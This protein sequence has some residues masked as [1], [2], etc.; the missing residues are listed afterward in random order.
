MTGR[1]RSVR[2]YSGVPIESDRF[3][4]AARWRGE[5]TP[6]DAPAG[7]SAESL[8]ALPGW[9]TWRFT[10]AT[11]PGEASRVELRDER[12]GLVAGWTL[13]LLV[14]LGLSCLRSPSP[15]WAIP[16]PIT[17]IFLAILLHLWQ[18]DDRA[19]FSAGLFVGAMASL[20]YRLGSQLTAQRR[21][22]R[23]VPV[24]SVPTSAPPFRLPLQATPLLLAAF[25]IPQDRAVARRDGGEPIPVLIPYEGT[26]QPGQ[27]PEHVIL[28]ESDHQR[29]QEL[30]R[31]RT[32][33]AK[34][35]LFLTGAV[36]H[37]F[38][39]GDREISLVSDLEIRSTAGVASTWRVPI[40]GAHDIT[41]AL[42]GREV[43]MFIEAGGQQAAI[44]IP[45]AGSFKLQVRRTAT[46]AT[47]GLEE[48]LDF[49]VNPM[50]S[51][52]LI[53]DRPSRIRPPRLLN[54]RGKLTAAGDQS[55]A[56]DLGPV[57]HVEI[58][59]GDADAAGSQVAGSIIES[60]ILWDIEP[61]GDR[62][63]G[64]FTYRGPRRLSTLSFQMDPGLMTRSVE[65]PG[66]IDSSWGGTVERPVWTARMD[67]PLQEGAVLLL[68]LWRPARALEGGQD[69]QAP[70]RTGRPA[71]RRGGFPALNLWEW[72][73]T[74]ACSVYAGR[75]TGR[76]GSSLSR[77]RNP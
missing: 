75:D 71:N 7:G 29:L 45:G 32:L 33:A 16:L 15:R 50:P 74:R 3:Q 22:D 39:S 70:R 49:P 67:P 62:L 56:A 37:V 47:E 68:D 12:S 8:R 18:A 55:L 30:A 64:R 63:R 35:A 6:R 4:T 76:A 13:A 28:R 42:D 41:A 73:V 48:S 21:A 59:W 53:M 72:S 52:R 10:G 17:I 20:L 44:T 43:P 24:R 54:A 40:T 9:T 66:L 51:A 34:N 5:I 58:R 77:A 19:T 46:V 61:A 14:A 2:H 65:I 36:H 38:W 11:W 1:E 57:D 25:L 26:F 60:M 31:P 23:S 27:V 69:E